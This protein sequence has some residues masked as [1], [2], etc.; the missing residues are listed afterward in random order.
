MP[1]WHDAPFIQYEQIR[2]N[3]MYLKTI[4]I[5]KKVFEMGIQKTLYQKLFELAVGVQNY[6]VNF[7]AA[8]RQFDWLEISIVSDKSGKHNTIYNIYNHKLAGHIIQNVEIENMTNT[9][10]IAN[11]LKSSVSYATEK[12]MLYMQF[13]AWNCNGCSIAPLMDCANNPIFQELTS[14]KDYFDTAD[15]RSYLD[16]RAI[17]GN[18]GELEKLHRNDSEITLKINLKA[19]LTK[20]MCLHVWGYS[21]GEYLYLLTERSRTMKYKAYGIAKKK[22]IAI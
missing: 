17:K 22:E 20:N 18:T 21:Q 13:V 2:L 10:S 4:L 16:L 5:S 15:E 19:A 11:K 3:D 1:K 6:T 12:Y 7:V 14:E 8:T 9:Y